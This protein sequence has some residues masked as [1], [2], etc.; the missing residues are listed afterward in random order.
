MGN[1]VEIN[2]S[3]ESGLYANVL[4]NLGIG[5]RGSHKHRYQVSEMGILLD[6]A[7]PHQEVAPGSWHCPSP[8]LKMLIR[9]DF[10][11]KGN[12]VFR[13]TAAHVPGRVTPLPQSYPA[14]KALTTITPTGIHAPDNSLI[15]RA[16]QTATLQNTVFTDTPSPLANYVTKRSCYAQR[17]PPGHYSTVRR[18]TPLYHQVERFCQD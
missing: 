14:D 9:R 1:P 6:S 16:E 12:F 3:A 17:D 13:V 18:N 4:H 2:V 8:N 7:V 11:D 15:K 10:P 5:M